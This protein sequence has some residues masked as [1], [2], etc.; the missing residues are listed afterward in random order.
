MSSA[1]NNTN[2]FNLGLG[3]GIVLTL[4]MK[5][6]LAH[7][8]L[9]ADMIKRDTMLPDYNINGSEKEEDAYE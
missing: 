8:K 9:H 3:K 6:G 2:Q 5:I 1:I 4:K 7:P